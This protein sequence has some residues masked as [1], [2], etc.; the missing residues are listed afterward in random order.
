[1]FENNVTYRQGLAF[2]VVSNYHVS[3]FYPKMQQTKYTNLEVTSM[4]IT[5]IQLRVPCFLASSGRP[6]NKTEGSEEF[7]VILVIMNEI[8]WYVL[9]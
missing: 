5:Q 6:Q 8:M 2:F 7:S 4:F 3:Q 9:M 1:M